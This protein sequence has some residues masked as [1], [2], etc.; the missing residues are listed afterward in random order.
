MTASLLWA[1]AFTAIYRNPQSRV[2]ASEWIYA[3]I[4]KGSVLASEHW[5][6]ALPLRIHGRD[7]Y[8]GFYQGVQMHW[9]AED[10]QQK[11]IEALTL[12]DRA[13]YIILSSNR[14]YESI[15]L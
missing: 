8:D 11:L 15:P 7:P 9:Y 10:T 12:L 1:V 4:P 2:A 6:D 14:L 3:N 5:D 13:D